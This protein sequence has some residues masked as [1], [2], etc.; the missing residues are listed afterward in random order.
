KSVCAGSHEEIEQFDLLFDAFWM[1]EGRVRQK[2]MPSGHSK[3]RQN[4]RNT[5]VDE[6]QS[7]SS[8]GAIHAPEDGEDGEDSYAEGTGKLVASKAQNLMKK[9]LREMVSAEDIRAAEQVAI[10]LGRALRDQRS[11]RRKAARRGGAIDLRRTMRASLSTGGEPLWL[12]KRKRPDRPLKIVALCDVSGSMMNYARPF[13]AFLAGLMR[14][15]D[16]SDAYLFHTRL[17]RIT[18]ALRDDDPIRAL[19]RITL[20]ADGFGGGSRIGANLAQ[21]ANTYARNFV[22]GRSVVIVLSDGYDS[23]TAEA[24]G[25][26]LAKLKRRGCKIVWLNPLKGWKDYTPVAKGMAA[27]LPHLDAFAAAT[28]LNDL[29]AL[30]QMLAQL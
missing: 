25:T 18:N 17:V 22:D 9:D 20:L 12:A 19:N 1:T 14:A 10:R 15:D 21:F 8:K 2:V 5:R 23:D 16:A 24:L 7:T 29:A 26:A 30:D 4:T 3:P 28:T 11:R 6:A 27:A 13:L